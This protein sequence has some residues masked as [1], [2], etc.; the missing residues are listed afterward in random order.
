M[1]KSEE[2]ELV[3]PELRQAVEDEHNNPTEVWKSGMGQLVQC[4][5]TPGK[6]VYV[7]FY[8][9]L[10]K[11]I[12]E[13]YLEEAYALDQISKVAAKLLPTVEWKVCSGTQYQTDFEFNSSRQVYDSIKTTLIYQFNYLLVR[14][15]RLHPIRPFD[16]EANCNEC[17]QMILGHR[18]KCT[19]CAD[20]DI[21]QRCE[22]RSIHP[23]HAMLRIV[24]KGTT[25]IPHYITANAPRYVFA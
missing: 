18:F 11:K 21:C 3:P 17:R 22:A 12:I 16:Q 5:G 19:E 23:E 2:L 10:D 14:L 15:E 13:L 9:H 4:S 6:K 8:T 24:S 25:H 1:D 7:T 20:F